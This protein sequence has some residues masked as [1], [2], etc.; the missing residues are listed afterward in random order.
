MLLLPSSIEPR[1]GRQPREAN[2][3]CCS[4]PIESSWSDQVKLNSAFIN[5]YLVG[6]RTVL[7]QSRH[8]SEAQ[9]WSSW[10]VAFATSRR[11]PVP[12]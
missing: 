12:V 10:V 4:D 2:N 3:T 7:I 5:R 11:M 6:I 1:W 9:R 8:M